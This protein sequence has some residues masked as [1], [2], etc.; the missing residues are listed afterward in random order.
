MIKVNEKDGSHRTLSQLR[1]C[2]WKACTKPATMTIK[3]IT[4]STYLEEA[5]GASSGAPAADLAS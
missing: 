1:R 3:Y 5:E 4:Q 2:C